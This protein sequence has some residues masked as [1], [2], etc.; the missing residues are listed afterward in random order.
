MLYTL[1]W[2]K[3]KYLSGV[4]NH[5]KGN[6]LTKELCTSFEYFLFFEKRAYNMGLEKCTRLFLFPGDAV[7]FIY[8]QINMASF[9]M[10]RINQDNQKINSM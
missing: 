2:K 1:F 8:L 4:H 3:E 7:G 9:T 10:M 6:Y 5:Y